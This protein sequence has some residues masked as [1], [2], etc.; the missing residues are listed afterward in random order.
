[1]LGFATEIKRYPPLHPLP[2]HLATVAPFTRFSWA[3][4]EGEELAV[5]SYMENCPFQRI[6]LLP[7]VRGWAKRGESRR[8]GMFVMVLVLF[9][10]FCQQHLLLKEPEEEGEEDK[11]I[12]AAALR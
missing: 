11:W 9:N 5:S 6:L 12:A 1:M 2:P 10:A 3:D 4:G 7:V 8:H